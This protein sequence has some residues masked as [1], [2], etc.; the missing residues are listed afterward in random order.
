[1]KRTTA[2]GAQITEEKDFVDRA[3]ALADDPRILLPTCC[4][5]KKCGSCP[6]DKLGEQLNKIS[7]LKDNPSKLKFQ[8]KWAWNE[9]VRAYAG[10]LLVRFRKEKMYFIETQVPAGKVSYLKNARAAKEKLIGVQHHDKPKW[11]LMAYMEFAK[12]GYNIYS[13]RDGLYCSGSEPAPPTQFV[14]DAVARS[15]YGLRADGDNYR[16]VHLTG[17]DDLT[18]LWLR[19]RSAGITFSICENCCSR[20]E[21]LFCRLSDAILARDA[22]DDF[23][24]GAA[25]GLHC[26]GKCSDCVLETI[27]LDP[28]LAE[29]YLSGSIPDKQ[30]IGEF[31]SDAQASLE[32]AGRKL[33]VSGND[34]FGS[35][36]DGFISVLNP[37]DDERT[38]LVT[39]LKK[40]DK[41][42]LL[43]SPTPSKVLSIFW[44]EYGVDAIDAAVK[45][46]PLATEIYEKYKNMQPAAALKDA[47]SRRR[48]KDILSTLPRYEALP[49]VAAVS[50]KLARAYRVGSAKECEQIIDKLDKKDM[51]LKSVSYAF[52][53]A[54]GLQ[55]GRGWQYTKDEKDFA[56]FLKDYARA[57]LDAKA[58]EYNEAL[59]NL[60]TA[61]GA[62]GEIKKKI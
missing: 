50:D 33:F 18:H 57:L 51:K 10:F 34:C 44:D 13:V 47:M 6:F 19:W 55:E 62:G 32:K 56:E 8:S 38:A 2:R 1:M 14:K 45:D 26:T 29:R 28:V 58:G 61:S 4:A 21:N 41:P 31:V 12:Q 54:L 15:R 11:R 22:R 20:D 17:K 7:E 39:I 60:L 48:A 40:V 5:H 23:E 49:P 36:M 9:L 16:C 30:I 43:D 37:S 3:D 53:L 27:G 59:K 25:L 42:V 52:L 35:D 24:V 46:R